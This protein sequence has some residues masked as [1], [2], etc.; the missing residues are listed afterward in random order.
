MKG[1]INSWVIGLIALSL[2]VLSYTM[3]STDVDLSNA[4]T[5]YL[6]ELA[7]W[8][9]DLAYVSAQAGVCDRDA[10]KTNI[11][12]SSL[13]KMTS[14]GR[15]RNIAFKTD[16]VSANISFVKNYPPYIDLYEPNNGV[17]DCSGGV[18]RFSWYA[19]EP[20]RDRTT[21]YLYQD[22]KLIGSCVDCTSL[23]VD[24]NEL[25]QGM[26]TFTLRASD[27]QLEASDS[28]VAEVVI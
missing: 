20:D 6:A 5:G 13:V 11:K 18:A 16:L 22:K 1:F 8:Y 4:K 17:I 2:V 10:L 3:Y 14:N 12:D 26:S 9:G 27:G 15:E 28:F 24:C 25:D 7:R 19:C 21:F 23:S